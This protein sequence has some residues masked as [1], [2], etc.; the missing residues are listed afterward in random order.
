MSYDTRTATNPIKEHRRDVRWKIVLPVALP[1][2]AL[3]LFGIGLIVAV[4]AGALVS[5]QI[6][7]IMGMLAT[8]FIAL[9]LMILCLIPYVLLAVSATFVGRGYARVRGPLATAR[10]LTQRV[11]VKTDERAPKVA[12]PFTALNVRVTRWEHM[13]RGLNQTSI[14]LGKDDTY[15]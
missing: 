10:E 9:P 7:V 4:A 2:L 3:A 13:L 5:A 11:A 1:A 6:T 12:R 14:V 15:E 8:A